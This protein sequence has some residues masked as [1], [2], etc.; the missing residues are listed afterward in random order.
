MVFVS[1]LA[2][3]VA[4]ACLVAVSSAHPGEH[5]D[6]DMIKRTIA[7]REHHAHNAKRSLNGCAGSLKHR[8]LS[9]RSIARRAETA[10]KLRAKRGISSS[11]C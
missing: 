7:A 1:K 10:R 8:D 9:A 2:G 5:H 4:A 11:K 6:H 3:V